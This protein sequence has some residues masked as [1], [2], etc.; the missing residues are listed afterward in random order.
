MSERARPVQ[1]QRVDSV[2]HSPTGSAGGRFWQAVRDHYKQTFV[3]TQ[4]TIAAITLFVLWKSQHLVAA[5]AFFATMQIGALAG[6][7][8]A[9]RLRARIQGARAASRA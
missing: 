9:A 7:I 5:A 8:W 3:G 2:L 4:V 6:A 1:P